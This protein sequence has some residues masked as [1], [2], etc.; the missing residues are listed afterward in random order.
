LLAFSSPADDAVDVWVGSDIYLYFDEMVTVGSG[1]ITI[2]N[3]TDIRTIDVQ[4]SSQVM[5][6]GYNSVFIN[7]AADLVPDTDYFIQMDNGLVTDMTG[8]PY[9][10]IHDTATLNFSTTD[11][12]VATMIFPPLLESMLF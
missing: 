4:D 7:P 5:F 9:A 10:D 3:G 6:D 1:H 12:P 2:S 11:S 8:N